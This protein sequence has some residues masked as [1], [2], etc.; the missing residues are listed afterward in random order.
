VGG[1][2]LVDA[3]D[4]QLV[5]QAQRGD[6]DAYAELVRRHQSA[7]RRLAHVI[8]GSASDGD[9]IAQDAMVKG[10]LALG[11]FRRRGPFRLWLLR[12][13]ANEA[14]NRRRASWRRAGYELRLAA[15]PVSG[16]AAPSPETAVVA[17]AARRATRDAVAALPRRHRDVV[18]CR[19]LLGL[20]EAETATVLGL[21]RGTVKSRTSRALEQL[22]VDL[23][24]ERDG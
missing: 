9:D 1:R 16:E 10:Y 3:D 18:A 13:V 2:P 17:D 19:Y 23:A 14:R 8:S 15:D 7:A 5:Q 4:D 21:A 20:S 12:I 22:R 24:G 11:R 6:V